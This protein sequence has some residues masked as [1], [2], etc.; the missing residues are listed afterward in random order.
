[1]EIRETE[2]EDTAESTKMKEKKKIKII[3]SDLFLFHA[4][5]DTK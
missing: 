5:F 3:R 1:V 4:Y 2:R